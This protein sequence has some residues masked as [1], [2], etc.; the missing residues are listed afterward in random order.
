MLDD[1]RH[2]QADGTLRAR[3]APALTGLA[4]RVHAKL[5]AD[6][7]AFREEAGQLD[8]EP[9][10]GRVLDSLPEAAADDF[11]RV[12]RAEQLRTPEAWREWLCEY[13]G[14]EVWAGDE[15]IPETNFLARA[16]A[17][18]ETMGYVK[19]GRLRDGLAVWEK[20]G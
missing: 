17:G 18:D 4:A 3:C 14:G 5:T 13:T 11:G 2:R 1:F 6:A 8:T 9:F 7:A 16:A 10:I 12:D 19:T 20:I 15:R